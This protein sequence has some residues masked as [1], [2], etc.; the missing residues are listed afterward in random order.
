MINSP[1]PTASNT[2]SSTSDC[3][4]SLSNAI[5]K[6]PQIS[7]NSMHTQSKV[8]ACRQESARTLQP[9]MPIVFAIP[10]TCF[11]PGI[12]EFQGHL[13]FLRLTEGVDLRPFSGITKI[14]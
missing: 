8:M 12:C 7:Q 2:F 11:M 5:E 10:M 9:Q 14:T 13:P 4:L 6:Y 3:M 1:I